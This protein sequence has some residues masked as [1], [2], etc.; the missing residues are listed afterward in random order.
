MNLKYQNTSIPGIPVNLSKL[1]YNRTPLPHWLPSH[2]RKDLTLVCH[3]TS[4]HYLPFIRE[5][6]DFVENSL[7]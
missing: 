4:V 6:R 5:R 2:D 7:P 1:K 3:Q